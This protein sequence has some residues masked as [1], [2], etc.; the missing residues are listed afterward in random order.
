[1]RRG[2]RLTL[3][4]V[5]L[6]I[7]GCSVL[8]GFE[9]FGDCRD[10]LCGLS[11]ADGGESPDSSN[12]ALCTPLKWPGPPQED[13]VGD[14]RTSFYALREM[15]FTAESDGG[16]PRY[17]INNRCVCPNGVAGKGT[18]SKATEVTCDD[19]TTGGDNVMSDLFKSFALFDD[20]FVSDTEANKSIARGDFSI[21]VRVDEYNGG[22]NDKQVS[23]SVYNALRVDRERPR[24]GGSDGT[25]GGADGAAPPT[26][27]PDERWVVDR[28]SLVGGNDISFVPKVFDSKA[29]VT[30]GTLVTSF[31]KL[32]LGM[33]FPRV[34]RIFFKTT[35]TR[36]I[37]P[38]QTSGAS[39]RGYVVGR[40]AV[41]SFLDFFGI[42]GWCPG[43]N[44]FLGAVEACRRA[45][46]N[47]A[48]NDTGEAPCDAISGTLQFSFVPT[49]RPTTSEW[50]TYSTSMC[51]EAICP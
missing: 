19:P 39:T 43:T 25:D 8:L 21:L 11:T 26:F 34:G 5:A 3:A 37:L 23:V 48:A 6:A 4:G 18:C 46:L 40:I 47:S 20:V 9:G 36:L 45:D 50:G 22:A 30:N 1:M 12:E 35:D 51:P 27:A 14:S 24:D 16:T 13:S 33:V 28:N 44:Q 2:R 41:R 49:Q 31:S 10:G 38:I 7:S 15:T 42:L 32:D 29:Y 17:D